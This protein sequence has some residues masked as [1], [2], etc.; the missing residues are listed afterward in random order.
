MK[1]DK[2]K[3]W[4]PRVIKTSI[5][6]IGL[7]LIYAAIT[8]LVSGNWSALQ[9]IFSGL[10]KVIHFCIPYLLILITKS[11]FFIWP[12]ILAYML[13]GIITTS[14]CWRFFLCLSVLAS[15]IILLNRLVFSH[16][17]FSFNTLQQVPNIFLYIMEIYLLLLWTVPRELWNFIGGFLLAI[18]SLIVTVMP[19]LPSYFDDLGMI[20][21]IFAFIFLYINT[22]ASIIQRIIDERVITHSRHFVAAIIK[23]I[24]L[25]KFVLRFHRF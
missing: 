18:Q 22:I 10:F 17:D 13:I 16:I 15:A 1:T 3:I 9:T 12:P 19:D 7:Y 4:T 25:K 6:L 23:K 11:L 2:I 8:V 14:R 21:A 5:I 24:P 20:L